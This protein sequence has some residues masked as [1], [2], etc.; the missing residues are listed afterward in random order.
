M[1]PGV[2]AAEAAGVVDAI[3]ARVRQL[4]VQRQDLEN[5]EV[6]SRSSGIGRENG[7]VLAVRESCRTCT[8]FEKKVVAHCSVFRT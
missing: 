4:N 2:A 7:G 3:T 6:R 1:A 8:R 5:R